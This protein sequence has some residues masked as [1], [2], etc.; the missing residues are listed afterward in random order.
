MSR[1]SL[2]TGSHFQTFPFIAAGKKQNKTV[3]LVRDA[4]E[5]PSD[6]MQSWLIA[7]NTPAPR[8][9]FDHPA[10]CCSSW[11]SLINKESLSTIQRTH[12]SRPLRH[13]SCRNGGTALR[14]FTLSSFFTPQLGFFNGLYIFFPVL[15]RAM[16]VASEWA[17]AGNWFWPDY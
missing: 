11:W 16:E 6:D 9:G 8:D 12:P 2:R 17:R 10:P 4:A 14:S 15:L 3:A 1:L 13:F 7:N 5:D